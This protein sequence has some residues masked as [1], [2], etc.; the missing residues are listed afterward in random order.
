MNRRQF[1]QL[2]PAAVLAGS[3]LQSDN[4]YPQI[5]SKP[6]SIVWESDEV[7]VNFFVELFKKAGGITKYLSGDIQKSTVLIK[8]NLCLP[9][10]PK[11]GTT[12]T[13]LALEYLCKALIDSGVKK[14]IIA[15][16]TLQKTSDFQNIELQQLPKKFPEVSLVL[17]N[18][19]RWYSPLTVNGNVLKNTEILKIIPKADLFINFATAKHH[20]ATHVSLC[21]K[22]L[23]GAIWNRNDFHTKMDLQQACGDL[24]LV[25]KP[26]LNIIDATRVLLSGGP[27]GPGPVISEN[28]LFA[29]EDILAVDSVVVSRYNFG[30]KSLKP[31]EVPHLLAA[32]KNQA[33]EIEMTNIKLVKI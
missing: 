29:S 33:G 12:T 15:D 17:A 7:S 14:I 22:N 24:P 18:E 20:T 27:T 5:N 13:P 31:T 8:P 25:I 19:E 2:A 28:K 11:N 23:M 10:L 4:L 21:V 9:H 6:P 30:G 26:H 32:Y 1:V 16:H 3:I